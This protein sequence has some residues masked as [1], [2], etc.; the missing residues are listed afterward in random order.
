M[1]ISRSTVDAFQQPLFQPKSDWEIPEQLPRLGDARA[2][3]LDIE[4]RDKDLT[5][6]G[7]GVRREGNYILGISIAVPEGQT[8]YLPFGHF[9]G[10]QFNKK[11]VLKWARQELCRPNQP[12]IGANLLYDLDWLYA[13]G[14]PVAGPFYDVQVAEPLID[15]NKRV[16]S[17]DS[18]CQ[19]YLGETKNE[20]LIEEATRP[21]RKSK[22][23]KPQEHLWKLP[24]NIV[25]PYAESDAIQ[26]IQIFLK[27]WDKMQ[28]EGL[29]DL[30]KMESALIPILLGMRQ[31]GVRVDMQ[32]LHVAIDRK[33]QELKRLSHQL[34]KFDIDPWANQSIGRYFKKQGWDYPRTKTGQPSFQQTWLE[35]HG[36]DVTK[37]IV[38]YRKVDK[39][40]GTFLRGSLLDQVIGDRIHCQFNQ[41]KGDEGGTVTGRFSSSNPNLQ[42]IP[43]RDPELGPLCRSI[44]IPDEGELWGRADYSQIEI[45]V[46]AHFAI[47]EGA[48]DI[49]EAFKNDRALDYHQW[50]ADTAGISRKAAKTINFG[51]IYGMG[52][53]K[54]AVSLGIPKDEAES[55]IRMYYEKLPFLKRTLN[56]ASSQAMKKGYVRTI[57]GRKRRFDLWEPNK[58]DLAKE[59]TAMKDK[60]KMLEITKKMGGW[61]VQRAGCYK[62]F[63]AIDQGSAADIMKQAMV[64]IAEAGIFDELGFPLLTVHDE[65]DWSVPNTP[66]GKEAFAES[67]RLM[68]RAIP[69]KLPV[70]VDPDTGR[71]WSDV[72]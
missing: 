56:T 5:T 62:A 55:F 39:F 50:C 1:E 20:D 63:N 61:G 19:E 70:V 7:P 2:I 11:V 18:L 45:R 40:I 41:L 38:D 68:E 71:D 47:G 27:Q 33:E 57:L 67:A 12:K 54:L 65:L 46:L 60:Q 31:R 21:F 52:A 49:R 53:A 35:R 23:S 15:E 44:F 8:W 51:I 4:T 43:G 6:K 72:K 3:G 28:R 25:G 26:P 14:V 9:E 69:L 10:P 42:F 29:I 17:L 58:F 24:S 30:F 66:A 32:K 36:S 59:V 64:D 48:D 22:K 13:E 16:Y 37:L 34:T